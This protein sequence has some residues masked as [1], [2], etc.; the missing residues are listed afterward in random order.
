MNLAPLVVTL[1]PSRLLMAILSGAHVGAGLILAILPFPVWLKCFGIAAIFVAGMFYL[2]RYASLGAPTAVRE[3]RMLSE[4]RLEIFRGE[5][6]PAELTGEQFVHPFL[7][8]IRCRTKKDRWPI[9][10]VILNDML[11][12]ESFRALRLRLKWRT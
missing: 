2:R 8:I 11:D 10:V 3:L 12:P 1:K 9:S 6:Q 5:W 7:T 4:N